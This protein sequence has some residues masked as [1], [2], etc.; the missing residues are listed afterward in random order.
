MIEAYNDEP[1]SALF[2][3]WYFKCGIFPSG[4]CRLVIDQKDNT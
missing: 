3:I 2:E 4:L 1:D